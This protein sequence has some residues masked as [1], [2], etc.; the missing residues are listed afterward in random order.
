MHA[1]DQGTVRRVESASPAKNLGVTSRLA[2]L[3]P[4]P[5]R[6][7][8]LDRDRSPIPAGPAPAVAP[9]TLRAPRKV[10]PIDVVVELETGAFFS[11]TLRDVST[12]GAFLV[13]KR[14]L[15]VGTIV[16]LEM[17]I[18]TTGSVVQSSHRVNA[19]I[20]RRTDVGC[21]LAFIDPSPGFLAAIEATTRE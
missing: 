16:T 13:T 9:A 2:L 20:A 7:T 3:K 15:E 12:S 4:P 8:S 10:I 19:R 5:A 6:A 14:A 11:T 1:L 17:K 18:P 21:G